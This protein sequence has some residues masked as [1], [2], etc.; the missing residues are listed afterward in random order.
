M[1][2]HIIQKR[3]QFQLQRG[4]KKRQSV[5]AQAKEFREEGGQY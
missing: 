1:T 5:V 3:W 2:P 4:K